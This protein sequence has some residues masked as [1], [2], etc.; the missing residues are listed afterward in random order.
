MN[1]YRKKSEILNLFHIQALCLFLFLFPLFFQLSGTIFNAKE[2][3][4]DSQASLLLLPLPI[5]SIFCYIGIAVLLRLEKKH[6]GVGFVFSIFILMMFSALVSSGASG[7]AELAKFILLVQFI[8]PMFALVLGSLYLPP[9]SDYLKVEAV[10]LYILMLI[11]PAEV[12]ATIIR[13]SGILSPYLYGFSLYQNL[14]YLPVI[15]VALY[16]LTVI[17][18]YSNNKLRYFV[19]FLAPWMGIYIAASLSI[20]TIVL[21]VISALICF[22]FLNESGKRGYGLTLVLLLGLSF[23]I[24]YPNVQSTG[25]YA[26]KYSQ[27]VQEEINTTAPQN[28]DSIQKDLSSNK[29]VALLPN[30][31]KERF[32]YWE[33]YGKGIFENPKIFIF[34][35]ANR[36]DRNMYPSAHNYYLDLIYH[37]GAIS[38]L[39]FIYLILI[40]MRNIWRVSKTGDLTPGLAVL[41]LMVGFLCLLITL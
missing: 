19:I 1:L 15:F 32:V 24:Y 14:Q 13:G 40:T 26:L 29:F 25:T 23:M 41:V 18:L 12:I 7:K 4:F 17:S 3:K 35:H 21:A 8:L 39:P 6:F 33:F 34:G 5:A 20:L 11:I 27:E 38:M 10:I 37:F 36:P 22:W 31:I 30:N 2:L 28:D 9:K 16:F